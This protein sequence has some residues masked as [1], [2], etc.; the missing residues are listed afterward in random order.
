M[1][2]HIKLSLL[3]YFYFSHFLHHQQDSR[4]FLVIAEDIDTAFILYPG[5]FWH[6][7]VSI[8]LLVE[9]SSFFLRSVGMVT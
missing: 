7:S 3:A 6:G 9:F 2:E 5:K 1:A 8:I 4:D